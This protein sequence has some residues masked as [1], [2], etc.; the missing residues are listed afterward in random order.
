MLR[1]MF[2]V[3]AVALTISSL[4]MAVDY[5]KVPN[6]TKNVK[7]G[8]WVS[9]KIAG[10]MEMKQV[11]KKVE[12]SGDERIITLEIE[13]IMGGNSMGKQEQVINMK[14]AKALEEK[15]RASN[16]DVKISEEDV[17]VNGK[18]LKAVVIETTV[19]GMTSKAY[20]SEE[21]PV[22]ALIKTEMSG[23][24]VTMEVADWGN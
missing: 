6:G 18:T 22:T 24:G 9:Y 11:V 8:Q 2:L 1:K 19:Q 3:A 13:T 21:I 20:M 5:S 15:A 23:M 14:E 17:T 7:E 10:G 12:G 4:S 16:P